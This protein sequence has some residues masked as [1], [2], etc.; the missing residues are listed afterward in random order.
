MNV[1]IRYYQNQFGNLSTD[2]FTLKGPHILVAELKDAIQEKFHVDP[3][4]QRLSFWFQS[5]TGNYGASI[6]T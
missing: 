1:Y 2:I 4:S 5:A 3:S 6:Q